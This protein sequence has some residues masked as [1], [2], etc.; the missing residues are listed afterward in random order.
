MKLKNDRFRYALSV[1]REC[2]RMVTTGCSRLPPSSYHEMMLA[3]GRRNGKTHMTGAFVWKE[4][5][6]PE[7]KQMV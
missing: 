5:F 7:M 4:F 3:L 1:S 6:A 2:I